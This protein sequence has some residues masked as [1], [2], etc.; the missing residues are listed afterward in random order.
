M[1]TTEILTPPDEITTRRQHL[2]LALGVI[3]LA[4]LMLVLD[5]LIVNTALPHI[6]GALHFSGTALE[7]VVTVY[8]ITFGGCSCSGADPATSLDAV[9]C[10]WLASWSSPSD[11]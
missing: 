6:E 1:A 11:R 4:Q 2:G 5:E 3:S 7:W 10:S 8:A 9:G